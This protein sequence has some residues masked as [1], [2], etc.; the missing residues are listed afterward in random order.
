[1][2]WFWSHSSKRLL[3]DAH[4]CWANSAHA[5]ANRLP[6]SLGTQLEVSSFSLWEHMA[7][8]D[9]G[10]RSYFSASPTC[11]WLRVWGQAVSCSTCAH[12]H[13]PTAPRQPKRWS[14]AGR[15]VWRFGTK[16]GLPKLCLQNW[17]CS[18]QGAGLG[19]LLTSLRANSCGVINKLLTAVCCVL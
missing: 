8:S 18:E 7:L 13:P 17:S 10:R 11:L 9:L 1:M 14:R 6:G 15:T 16:P 5:P 4:V 2:V 19:V 3:G 12:T